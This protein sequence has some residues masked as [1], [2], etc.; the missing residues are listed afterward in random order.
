VAR[1]LQYTIHWIN[2]QALLRSGTLWFEHPQLGP[3]E[4]LRQK[5]LTK[6]SVQEY[7]P[8]AACKISCDIHA[9][10]QMIP[11]LQV[12]GF[13][14]GKRCLVRSVIEAFSTTTSSVSELTAKFVDD[15][16]AFLTASALQICP[17][18]RS[19]I[20]AFVANLTKLRLCLTVNSLED[21]HATL[22]GTVATSLSNASNLRWLFIKVLR[23]L[24]RYYSVPSIPRWMQFLK[25]SCHY[26]GLR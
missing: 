11:R 23:Q 2:Q 1:S 9:Y 20:S 16:H 6:T 21:E 8:I 5:K 24:D 22:N 26:T 13:G 12:T 17:R 4:L 18:Q 19:R 15:D 25:A 14:N 7:Y 3:Y 10:F